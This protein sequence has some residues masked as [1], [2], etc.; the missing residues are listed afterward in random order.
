MQGYLGKITDPVEENAVIEGTTIIN[1]VY[2]NCGYRISYL[3]MA[4]GTFVSPERFLSPTL[5]YV[6]KGQLRIAVMN[7]KKKREAVV[8]EGDCYFRP[9]KEYAGYYADESDVVLCESVLR[10]DSEIA[11]RIIPHAVLELNHLVHYEPGQVSRSHL[12]NDEFFQMNMLA[13]SELEKK[14]FKTEKR[15][16]AVK[17]VEGQFSILHEETKYTLQPGDNFVMPPDY[18]CYI[19]A[20]GRTKILVIYLAMP[21]K[22]FI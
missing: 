2:D 8:K 12:V 1:T 18:E 16:V 15:P 4:K 22:N 9:A 3:S 5:I 11:M 19:S 21:Q 17:C 6:L 14:E 13:Y 20:S 7:P 10:I